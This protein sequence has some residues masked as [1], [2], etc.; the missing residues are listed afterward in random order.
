ML[1]KASSTR[2]EKRVSKPRQSR[3]S[4]DLDP[5][6]RDERIFSRRR[7]RKVNKQLIL[8]KINRESRSRQ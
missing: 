1:S 5:D 3:N 8:L 6:L 4:A 7:E 2:T